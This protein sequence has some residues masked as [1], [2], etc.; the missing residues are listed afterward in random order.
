MER[1]NAPFKQALQDWMLAN[2]TSSWY[3]GASIASQKMN[4]HSHEG[5]DMLTP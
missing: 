1:G 3:D 4:N 5:R 2:N